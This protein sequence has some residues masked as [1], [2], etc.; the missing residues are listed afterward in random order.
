MPALRRVTDVLIQ[1]SY[2]CRP[3]PV[4]DGSDFLAAPK[5]VA[6]APGVTE[7][8]VRVPII[9][10]SIAEDTETFTATL[11][12]ADGDLDGNGIATVTIL[13]DDN[14]SESTLI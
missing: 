2:Y 14:K 13:D 7:D 6:F 5:L 12:T 4:T 8:R 11:S 9:D 1:C 3:F 10:D